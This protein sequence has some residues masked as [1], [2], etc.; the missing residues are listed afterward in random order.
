VPQT[1]A[2]WR[3]LVDDAA[4]FPPGNAPPAQ[5][6]QAHRR[7]REAAYADVVGPFV[8]DDARLPALVEALGAASAPLAV[9]LVVKGGVRAVENAVEGARGSPILDPRSVEVALRPEDDLAGQVRRLDSAVPTFVEIPILP[10][11][12]SGSWL[13][14]VDEIAAAGHRLKLRTGGVTP[15]AFPGTRALAG[16]IKAALERGVSFKCT[17]GLHH[18]LRHRDKDTGL[19]RHGFLNVLVAT[20]AS[21]SGADV[22]DLAALLNQR[23][24]ATLLAAVEAPEREAA[25]RWFTSFGC[26]DVLDPIRDLV[27]LDLLD[28]SH[29]EHA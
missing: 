22:G 9:T 6:V 23:D 18:A 8:V 7:H 14:C 24:A 13:A 17:A 3:R 29:L 25:R 27:A 19:Q 16:S 4:M 1:P 28:H 12:P 10:A 11:G 2:A 26:C 20:A 21:E 15:E 5:A